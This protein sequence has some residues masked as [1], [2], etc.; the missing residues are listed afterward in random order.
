MAPVIVYHLARFTVERRIQYSS[1]TGMRVRMP[2][3]AYCCAKYETTALG[4][5]PSDRLF[6]MVPHSGLKNCLK[7]TL[8]SEELRCSPRCS[9]PVLVKVLGTE[10]T[11]MLEIA[12]ATFGRVGTTA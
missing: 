12:L 6:H 10:S 5:R 7:L 1:S 3:M 8:N 4:F 9:V 2:G 11:D